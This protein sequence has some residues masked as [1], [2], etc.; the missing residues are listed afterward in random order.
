MFFKVSFEIIFYFRLLNISPNSIK[1]IP[2]NPISV[3]IACMV[4]ATVIILNLISSKYFLQCR[5][6]LPLKVIQYKNIQLSHQ[7]DKRY[8][9]LYIDLPL[10]KTNLQK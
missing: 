7:S 4:S 6:L 8:T 3:A 1:T 2:T 10:P 5:M 9:Y